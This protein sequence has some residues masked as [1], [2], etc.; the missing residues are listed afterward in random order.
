M[1]YKHK[2]WKGPE[3]TS[4]DQKSWSRW[5]RSGWKSLLQIKLKQYLLFN[6][7]ISRL[8]VKLSGVSPI[9]NQRYICL[10]EFLLPHINF[11]VLAFRPWK[12]NNMHQSPVRK[13]I[14]VM[15]FKTPAH[16]YFIFKGTMPTNKVKKAMDSQKFDPILTINQINIAGKYN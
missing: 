7:F 6:D 10:F 2:G 14:I 1:V 5:F 16:F 3:T 15:M 13:G 8:A 11:L 9:I 4:W 12:E